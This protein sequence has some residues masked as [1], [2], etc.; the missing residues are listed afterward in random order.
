[1]IVSRREIAK[2]FKDLIKQKDTRTMDQ[3]CSSKE[4]GLL[5]QQVFIQQYTRKYP[6][7]NKLLLYH[8][9]GSGKTCTSILVAEDL[10]AQDKKIKV[11]LPA[12]LKTNYLDELVTPCAMN[13][14]ISKDDALLYN[15]P[16]TPVSMKEK[17]RNKF[18]KKIE[19]KYDIMSFDRLK[20]DIKGKKLDE[21]IKNFTKNSL[22][23]VDEVHNMVSKLNNEIYEQ[24]LE[25]NKIDKKDDI[26]DLNT[27]VLRLLVHHADP[28]CKFLFMT[29]TPVFDNVQQYKNLVAVMAEP[30]DIPAV[31]GTFEVSQLTE[32]LR[33]KVSYYPG[34]SANAY[35]EKEYVYHNLEMSETIYNER[36]KIGKEGNKKESFKSQ[37]RQALLF[38]P[39][40]YDYRKNIKNV[41]ENLNEHSPKM[42]ELLNQLSL[43]GKHVVF[44]NFVER[45]INIVTLLLDQLGWANFEDVLKNNSWDKYKNKVYCIWDGSSDNKMKQNIK[46][47]MN[48]ADN[49]FGE[50]IKVVIG[51]PSIKE[52]VS[53]FQVQHLHIL[54]PIWNYS[55]K[56]Q[57]EGR[58]SRYCSHYTI[59]EV[60]DNPLLRKVKIHIYKIIA[61]VP[62]ADMEI[63]DQIIPQ[64]YEFVK[65]AENAIKKVAIDYYLFVKLY[66]EEEVVKYKDDV[67]EE[68][69]GG[70]SPIGAE[71]QLLGKKKEKGE[72]KEKEEKEQKPCKEN[73]VRN[74]ITKRCV[75][76][77]GKIGKMILAG[78]MPPPPK[79]K[80]ELK[81]CKEGQVRN[82]VSKRCVSADGKLG[83]KIISEMNKKSKSP[84]KSSKKKSKSPK[85]PQSY[86]KKSSKKKVQ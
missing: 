23:I 84:K 70:K 17:I 46:N 22:I 71:Q 65:N 59:D 64:K 85:K 51:S 30:K 37:E 3:I 67:V 75:S 45:G 7:W 56:I 62:T 1:M 28:S 26:E 55:T 41:L 82:P 39:R 18:I 31:M 61:G 58:A 13:R 50:K 38:S 20:L 42:R 16:K 43:P 11:I 53:F 68:K 5:P 83:K 25:K 8:E 73:Q 44:T 76:R 69:Y 27:M 72:I 63:Y 14:Y 29:A 60:K 34:I 48:G 66:S 52:G 4:R 24:V 49:K 80:G 2:E 6:N 10:I 54:D 86:K 77:D 12:R 57:I 78:E 35:P 33:G 47:I 74:P 15:E 81:P 9:I 40:S 36:Q 32:F 19:E 79:K 21:W